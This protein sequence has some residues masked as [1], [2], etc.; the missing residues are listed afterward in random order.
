MKTL[1]VSSILVATASLLLAVEQDDPR[2][3]QWME[4]S[5][6]AFGNNHLIADVKLESLEDESSSAECRYD[7]YPKKVER[8]QLPG[9]RTYARKQGKKWIQSDDWG[10]SGKPAP[11]DLV[12]QLDNFVGYAGI[13]LHT[14]KPETRDKS[15]GAIVVRLV[16]QRTTD[17]GDEEFVFEQGREKQHADLNYPKFTFL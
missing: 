14:E 17:N 7:R 8:I 15:Q 9:G 5:L 4:N 2:F 12:R 1:A 3:A 11:K 13:P 16:D 6:T 10:E